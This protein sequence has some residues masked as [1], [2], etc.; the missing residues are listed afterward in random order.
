MPFVPPE[1]PVFELP[2]GA[3]ELSVVL[4]EDVVAPLDEVPS[5]G[6]LD[7]LGELVVSEE[8]PLI[9][10]LVLPLAPDWSEVLGNVEL[11]P[12]VELP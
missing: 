10:L 3:L 6:L 8:L 5:L 2:L 11:E 9:P 4:G 1:V 12:L 7:V